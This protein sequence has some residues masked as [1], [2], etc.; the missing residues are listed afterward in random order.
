MRQPVVV[1]VVLLA[2]SASCVATSHPAQPSGLGTARTTTELL[3]VLDELGPVSVE[4]VASARWTVRLRGLLNLDH[5]K[6]KAAGFVDDDEA[7]LV[8]FHALRHPTRGLFLIDTGVERAL[9]SSPERAA[10]QGLIV[11]A[12]KLRSMKIDHDLGTF[13]AEQPAPVAGVLFTHLHFDHTMGLP[14]VPRG[15]PLYAGPGDTTETSV[16]NLVAAPNLDRA[17]AG[18]APISEWAFPKKSAKTEAF[19]GVVDVFD[20]GSVWALWLPG[21]T[22]GTTAYLVRT[23]KG[24][25]LFTGDVSHTRWGW[26]NDVEPGAFSGDVVGAAAS[27]QRLRAF[28]RAHPNI[29]V[30]VGHQP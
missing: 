14:D 4:T 24:P 13:L 1:V 2:L 30:R 3:K 7:V 28:A 27:F 23:P 15:T 20:D 25:V 6:A 16:N 22:P 11:D 8:T 21:H 10:T 12:M 29:E 26:D 5:E 19:D 9:R 18:H 17:L